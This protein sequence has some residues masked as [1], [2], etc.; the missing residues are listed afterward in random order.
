MAGRALSASAEA[1]LRRLAEIE[2]SSAMT[3]N[4][5]PSSRHQW[6]AGRHLKRL[7]RICNQFQKRGLV[8]TAGLGDPPISFK[9]LNRACGPGIHL[10]CKRP[11]EKGVLQKELLYARD[12][13]G[14][15]LGAVGEISFRR[16]GEVEEHMFEEGFGWLAGERK[17]GIELI[18][19][20]RQLQPIAMDL[21][22]FAISALRELALKG[23]V[24]PW[25]TDFGLRCQGGKLRS[26]ARLRC[27]SSG[28]KRLIQRGLLRE[29]GA[30]LFP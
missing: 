14:I 12:K 25:I 15:R 24:E 21:Q 3:M 17:S 9:V 30:G 4:A 23:D 16:L 13:A 5:L 28:G 11:T 10:P 27:W 1:E 6:L 22:L 2:A 20:D 26:R 7:A 18:G 29:N 19:E 8:K